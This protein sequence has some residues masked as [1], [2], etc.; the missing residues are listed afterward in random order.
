VRAMEYEDV[1]A[2][3]VCLN[4]ALYICQR[5][6]RWKSVFELLSRMQRVEVLPDVLS[7][8]SA[9]RAAEVGEHGSWLAAHAPNMARA[10]VAKLLAS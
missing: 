8:D 9:L 6:S 1:A 10:A 3:T 2:N 7:F 4:G 5:A